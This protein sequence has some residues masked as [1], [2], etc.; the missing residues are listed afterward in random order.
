M[1]SKI[2]WLNVLQQQINPHFLFNTLNNLYALTLKKSDNAPDLVMQLANLLRYSVYE[3][4]K[5]QVSLEKEINYL[6]VFIALQRLR[7]AER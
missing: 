3:G 4:Q 1:P 7:S 5:A 6:K 2:E